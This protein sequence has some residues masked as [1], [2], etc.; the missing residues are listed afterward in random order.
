MAVSTTS[1]LIDALPLVRA[2]KESFEAQNKR[3]SRTTL[4]GK[5][6]SLHYAATLFE[7]ME[8]TQQ[9]FAEL[10]E[11]L[12]GY[13]LDENL[14]K[15]VTEARS[16]ATIAI[17]ILTRSLYERT[18]DVGFLS[19]DSDLISALQTVQSSDEQRTAIE[20]RLKAYAS[21]YTVYKEIILLHADGSI[22]GRLNAAGDYK[23][24]RETLLDR[25]LASDTYVQ[26]YGINELTSERSLLFLNRV[27]GEKK[28]G[29]LVMVFDL[30]GE[31][32]RIFKSLGGAIAF[33]DNVSRVVGSSEPKY[34]GDSVATN[35]LTP[36]G[37]RRFGTQMFTAVVAASKG[38]EGYGGIGWSAVAL[39]PL[40]HD[41]RKSNADGKELSIL[42]PA[43]L[44]E[45]VSQ[46]EEI[47]E[48]LGDVVINGE[49]IAS[50]TRAYAL[51]PLLENI[52]IIGEQ[53]RAIFVQT[54]TDLVSAVASSL[55]N[56]VELLSRNVLEL[57]D[58]S[59]YER[60]CDCRWWAQESVFRGGKEGEATAALEWI[61]TLYSVYA[62]I[63]I[64]DENG[65]IKAVSKRDAAKLVGKRCDDEIVQK[66]LANRDPQRYSIS[67]FAP[68][69][70]YN[71]KP[72]YAFHATILSGSKSVGGIAAVFDA[73][74]QF[75][76]IIRSA[77][78]ANDD[79]TPSEGFGCFVSADK[80]IIAT[81]H[82]KLKPLDPL[83]FEI[84]RFVDGSAQLYE[85]EGKN[86]IAAMGEAKG[87]REYKNGG[88]YGNPIRSLIFLPV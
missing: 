75:E 78:G 71:D 68:T 17:D 33:V 18:A 7:F 5:I 53:T 28:L 42:L 41:M 40:G 37:I 44:R 27:G 4:T 15:S 54:E 83:P 79:G 2:Y 86:Y 29:V 31:F 77:V 84:E 65:T 22:V 13:L 23:R 73:A 20:A 67:P 58:R 64:Y 1:D 48:D 19:S 10:Q 34:F 88:E 25:A 81:T 59:L 32:E 60:A 39:S 38:F 82:P 49:L 43:K 74:P 16:R 50:K 26:H 55:F 46:S 36:Y 87:Y 72:T 69:P 51:N 14:K 11:R 62:L 61:G 45:I 57:M 9:N 63:F 80:R 76:A 52:R 30:A 3:L 8:K 21:K 66:V 24:S 47:S 56:E 35:K 12:V 85:Y 6:S 70:Y